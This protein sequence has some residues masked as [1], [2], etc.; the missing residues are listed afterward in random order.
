M[1][2][3]EASIWLFADL[4]THPFIKEKHTKST[5]KE[6]LLPIYGAFRAQNL[7]A[8]PSKSRI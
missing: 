1:N 2:I 5:Y 8:Q 7:F 6:L 4:F 3:A